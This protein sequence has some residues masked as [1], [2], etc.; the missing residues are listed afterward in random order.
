MHGWT[1]EGPELSCAIFHLS[2][3]ICLLLFTLVI[4]SSLLGLMNLIH[5]TAGIGSLVD[6]LALLIFCLSVSVVYRRRYP[7]ILLHTP[8]SVGLFDS[9]TRDITLGLLARALNPCPRWLLRFRLLG[10]RVYQ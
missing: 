3:D 9:V 7:G 4:I 6:C 2:T 8:Y 5:P 1:G 10:Y